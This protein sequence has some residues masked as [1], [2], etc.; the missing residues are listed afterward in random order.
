MKTEAEQRAM[1]PPGQEGVKSPTATPPEAARGKKRSSAGGEVSS[2]GTVA[3]LTRLRA[4]H[5]WGRISVLL[6]TTQ[7]L[8]IR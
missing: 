4:P 2:G 1:R 8:V 5:D 6:Y 7:S 3:P